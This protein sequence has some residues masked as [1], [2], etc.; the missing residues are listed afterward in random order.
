MAPTRAAVLMAMRSADKGVT[1][2]QPV[3]VAQVQS[4][5]A[6]DPESGIPIRDGANLGSIAAGRNGRIAMA[7]QDSRF[8]GGQRD[9]IAYSQSIDGGLT[10]STPVRLNQAPAVQAFVPTVHIRDDGTIGVT[11]YDFRSNTQDANELATDYWLAQSTDGITWRESRVAGPLDDGIAPNATGF[12]IGDYMGL[13][14]RGAEFLRFFAVAN[15]GNTGNPSGAAFGIDYLS[16]YVVTGSDRGEGELRPGRRPEGV[17]HLGT[18]TDS[19]DAG[20]RRL[21]TP[22]PARR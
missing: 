22:R 14:I 16:G 10:W 6:T 12:F 7:W 19:G 17:S 11:Y 8:S 13:V 15:N 21:A 5:G 18:G 20:A 3:V 1:W 2:S 9:G 4:R